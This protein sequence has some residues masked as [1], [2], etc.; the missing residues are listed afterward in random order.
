MAISI[1][2]RLLSKV[3]M[4]VF[5]VLNARSPL[6]WLYEMHYV[7]LTVAACSMLLLI[8]G[9][10]TMLFWKSQ[11]LK[12]LMSPFMNFSKFFY[13]S[14]LKPHTR[15]ST[16]TGQQAALESF[17]KVQVRPETQY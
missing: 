8:A 1:P 15:D 9:V 7:Q 4:S 14:F 5:G 11:A 13:A 17:Y 6:T 10:C 2:V 12:D 16:L 3:R